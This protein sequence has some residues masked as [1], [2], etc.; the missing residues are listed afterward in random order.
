[1]EV[2]LS[3]KAIRPPRPTDDGEAAAAT[4]WTKLESPSKD[5]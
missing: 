4:A 5:M 3:L 2:I 1:M